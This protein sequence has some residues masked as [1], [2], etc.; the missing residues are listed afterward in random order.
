MRMFKLLYGEIFKKFIVVFI[1][2]LSFLLG[3]ELYIAANHIIGK[4]IPLV[5]V[6]KFLLYMLPSL[7]VDN[8][9]ISM[10]FA[11]VLTIST[12][13][14]TN[15]LDALSTSGI[16]IKKLYFNIVIMSI[17]ISGFV[18]YYNN[19]F[20]PMMN[21]K[22]S[23]IMERYVS[24]MVMDKLSPGVF[25]KGQKNV[26]LYFE[27][28]SEDQKLENIFLFKVDDY[29]NLE[30]LFFAESGQFDSV[31][32]Q[33]LL[34]QGELI[35]IDNDEHDQN[36]KTKLGKV[37]KYD[38]IFYYMGREI[39]RYV[40]KSQS[41]FTMDVAKLRER[42]DKYEADCLADPSN[43][44]FRKRRDGCQVIYYT[45]MSIPLAVVIFA[46]TLFPIATFARKSVYSGLMLSFLL[47]G[48]YWALITYEY[49]LAFT[50][51]I[52]PILGGWGHILIYLLIAPYFYY[53]MRY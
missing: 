9:P 41:L 45:K 53:K 25:V 28:F 42:L 12:M 36:S 33:F 27:S 13:A 49:R 37:I 7:T 8:F 19:K 23:S 15:E 50:G 17:L 16:N 51:A 52:P 20:V 14:A 32:Q 6:I 46:I 39:Y 4:D 44:T 11:I 10:L 47:F 35:S 2:S 18:F 43:R 22:A 24:S 34:N 40:D 21:E 31:E 29:G 5:I 48:G 3:N 38:R 1:I 26:T 30:S